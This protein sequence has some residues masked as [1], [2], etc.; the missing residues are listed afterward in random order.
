MTTV[1]LTGATGFVGTHLLRELLASGVAVRALS[2]S[3]SADASLRAAGAVPV[4][5]DLAEP[6]SLAAAVDGAL[7]AVF[8]TAAD[9]STWRAEAARQTVVNVDGTRALAR[10]AR[11]AGARFVHTASVSSFSHLAHGTLTEDTPRRGGESWVNYERSK[12][13]GEEAVRTEMAAGLQA[14]I[15]YPAHIFGPG[16]TH[17][18]SRLV[19]LVD[20]G[21]LPGAPPGAGAFADVREVAR[22]HVAAWQRECWGRSYLLGGEH[23]AF[24]DLI[25]R[26]GARLHRPVP[27]RATPAAALKAFAR[28]QELIARLRGRKPTLTAEAAQFT[29][30]DLR[31]DSSR[32]QRELDYRI[33]PLDR[34]LDDT[35]GWMREAGML[36][37]R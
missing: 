23:A 4:R 25:Q 29:C 32:A 5:G 18:W 10:A 20:R 35:I 13:L 8:H 27:R 26:I 36:V 6:E 31:V 11:A 21:E 17:N 24:L 12:Y 22:A 30:H 37:A 33:T 15:L 14:T 1:L 34:L 3:A 7:D 19:Q 9:T 28:V 2:R 16:D